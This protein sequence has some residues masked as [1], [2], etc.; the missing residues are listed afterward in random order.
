MTDKFKTF[1][2]NERNLKVRE[3]I[4]PRL[5]DKEGREG[6][7]TGP[8]HDGRFPFYDAFENHPNDPYIINLARGIVDSWLLS[9]PFFNEGEY[10][11]GYQRPGR[12]I[13]EHFSWGITGYFEDERGMALKSRMLPLDNDHMHARGIELMGKEAYDWA[14]TYLW[15]TGGYQGHTVPSYDKLLKLGIGGTLEQINYYD[16]ITPTGNTKKKNFYKACRIIMEGF[17]KWF[18]KL[19]SDADALADK[20]EG[21]W[22][23]QLREIAVTCRKVSLDTPTTFREAGQLMWGYCLWDWVDCIG[24]F[25][26]Y[27]YPFYK[28]TDEEK[29][30]LADLMLKFWEHGVHNITIGG[31]KPKDGSPAE[32]E[33]TYLILN[34]IRANHD[35]HPRVS[36]RVHDNTPDEL[37][38]YI[39]EIW[40]DQMSD[41]TVASDKSIIEGL[42]G[43][44]VT[45]EDA[46]NYTV[47]GCQEIEI[48][49]KSN[50]GCED[51]VINL[52][53]IFELTMYNG[54]DRIHGDLQVGLA[55]GNLTDFDTFDKL[56]DAY[57]KNIEYFTRIFCDL[58]DRGVDIRIANVSKLVKSCMTEACVERGLQLDE[59]GSVYN[60]GCVETGGHAAVGDSLYAMKKL[61]YDEKKI[62]LETLDAALKANFEGYE[63]VKR[64]LSDVPKY[65]NNHDEADEMASRVLGHF[66]SE[67][68]KYTTRRGQVFTG[69]CSLLG[70]GT[71][72]GEVTGAL[73]DGRRAGEALG[74]T[75]GPRTGADKSGVTAMLSSVTKMPLHLGMGGSGCNVLFPKEILQTPDSRKKVAGLVRTFMTMGGQLAQITTASKEDMIDA[76]VHPED[77]ENLI[78]RIGGFSK[79]FNECGEN[80]KD[81]LI[82]RYGD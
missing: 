34:M 40:G 68:G 36:V 45:L 75:I 18:I 27:M 23:D 25:D 53:K 61:V 20:T 76:K 41:P 77:H 44:G 22:A 31:V 33:L 32:N 21:E 70:G 19:A 28:G 58:C 73:P 13:A 46:R 17:S 78:V 10:F 71:G 1:V 60:Y 62:S 11:A 24:R 47:L 26:Q 59:G 82:K 55:L 29:Y 9:D 37:L 50:F 65:G 39:A 69:A 6:T 42:M 64:M 5:R 52:A 51:G 4:L 3:Q 38:E 80:T 56:W 16:S 12:G 57:T 8:S 7:D 15:G 74:N 63:D 79:K 54:R 66:W 2:Y 67:I 35:V 30:M 81:E 48:P 43:Y 14:Y 72:M 49:G